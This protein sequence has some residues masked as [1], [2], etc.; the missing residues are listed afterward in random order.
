MKKNIF[1][2]NILVLLPFFVSCT[3]YL[4]RDPHTSTNLEYEQ[5]FKD[6]HGAPGFLNNA[7]NLLPVGFYY[8]GS[9]A[10]L[11]SASDEAKHSEGG[12]IVQLLSN[13]AIGASSDFGVWSDMYGGIRKCNIFLKELAPGGLID[14]YNTIP[15][16]RRDNYKGQALFLRAFFHFELLKHYQNIFC[17]DKVLDPFNEDEIFSIPQSTFHQAVDFIVND[18]DS[19]AKY[20]PSAIAAKE[21]YGR[22]SEAAPLALKS[23]LLLYAASPLNNPGN[24]KELW[25]KAEASAK[26]VY[27]KRMEL[28][29]G[30]LAKGSYGRIFTELYNSEIIFATRSDETNQIERNNFPISYQGKGLTNPTQNLVDCYVMNGSAYAAPM[31]GYD[32][33]KPYEKR[34]DRFYATIL[35]NDASFKGGKI[36]SFVGGKDGINSTSTA[37]KTGYYMRKF[38]SPDINLDKN[39]GIRRQWILFRYAEIILN[40]A[41][42]RN[43]VLENPNDKVLHDLLNLIRNRAGLRPFRNTAEYIKDK[44]EMREYIKKERRVELALEGHRFW[45]VRRWKDI[46]AIQ[47]PIEGIRIEKEQAGVD[48]QGKPVYKFK[49]QSFEVENRHFDTK[50]YWYPIPHAEIL[51]YR[52]KGINIIQNTGW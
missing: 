42:A 48:D 15:V 50:F 1:Y 46:D 34:E 17:V 21:E 11:A 25:E 40:Y 4:D 2:T 18:C 20:L 36:E 41:E 24:E 43:E 51:K 6:P 7:Y 10:L 23:R 22:P 16:A 26:E 45:D 28:G 19:A 35:Y 13:T 52:N 33:E 5:I 9:E 29:L 8:F 37:T 47:K 38:V 27:D 14:Q 12:S 30:L 39:E 49:Y 31:N 3:D 44:E 32:P